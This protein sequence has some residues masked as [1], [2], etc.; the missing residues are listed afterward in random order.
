MSDAITFAVILPAAGRSTR[1]AADTNK[2]LHPLDGRPII[3]HAAAA[4]LARSDVLQIV[5]PTFDP[6]AVRAA[7]GPLATDHRIEFRPGGDCRAQSVQNALSRVAPGIPW[8]AVHDAARPLISQTLID[9]TLA[10]AIAHRAAVAAL[11][12]TLTIKQADGPLPA[13]VR[14]TVPRHELWAVQTPQIM[15]R[16]DLADAFARCPI[17]LDQITDD[18]QLLEL[19]G[20]PV[21]LIPGEE[22]NLKITS[23]QDLLLAELLIRQQASPLLDRTP[24]T[25]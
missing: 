4:F 25:P 12:V 7:L 2:L 10:A 19:T 1:F 18:T 14:K 11:P 20:L 24:L 17:P 3:A 21:M 6:E 22:R 16:S 5:I 15:S 23:R 9:R 13:L 8:V